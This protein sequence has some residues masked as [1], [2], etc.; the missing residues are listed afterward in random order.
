[1]YK[2]GIELEVK[3]VVGQ[4][5][6]TVLEHLNN[7]GIPIS[8]VNYSFTEIQNWVMKP[9]CS[10]YG[11]F[12]IV[13]KPL[14]GHPEIEAEVEKMTK[15]LK[16]LVK[17][18]RQCGHH[19]HISLL[20]KYWAR[21]RVDVSTRDGRRTAIKSKQVKI[22]CAKLLRNYAHF[23]N[24]LD[25]IV[26]P[27]RRVLGNSAYNEPIPSEFATQTN[28]SIEDYVNTVYRVS[29]PRHS[30]INYDS[31]VKYGTVE[32][33]QFQGTT[34]KTKI[35]NWM[36]LCERFCARTSD[37]KYKNHS[38]LNYPQTIDGLCDFLG[39]G[40]YGVRRWARSRA[41]SNGFDDLAIERVPEVVNSISDS[42]NALRS[43]LI[44]HSRIERAMIRLCNHDNCDN[45][46]TDED[47]RTQQ[48]QYGC[49]AAIVCSA[50]EAEHQEILLTNVTNGGGVRSEAQFAR[51]TIANRSIALQNEIE[52]HMENDA[53]LYDTIRMARER[54][55][56]ANEDALS[57]QSID[58][59]VTNW[60]HRYGALNYSSTSPEWDGVNWDRLANQINFHE[61]C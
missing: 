18:D 48:S 46:I 26:S 45:H 1:M 28:E 9:D 10:L 27:S 38:P 6:E 47:V 24:V 13:S 60:N 40:K 51:D 53:A 52:L 22:F 33:R 50:C 7:E 58:I 20:E 55:E 34:N 17:I 39:F 29:I 32:F 36:K 42:G 61:L 30:V 44:P 35:M 21:R 56:R 4:N 49:G 57:A 43:D 8:W 14:T 37:R 12:E 11:G 16:G 3:P 31:L 5:R 15:A 2:V 54:R 25:S 23:Q 59:I 41:L 19:V